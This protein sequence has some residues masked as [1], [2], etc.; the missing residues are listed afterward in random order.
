MAKYN[1]NFET[2][3][4]MKLSEIFG[5]N[6]MLISELNEKMKTFISENNLSDRPPK[7]P[8]QLFTSWFNKTD[9][10]DITESEYIEQIKTLGAKKIDTTR[11]CHKSSLN[12]IMTHWMRIFRLYYQVSIKNSLRLFGNLKISKLFFN[13]FFQF[14]QKTL[15][16][17]Q[18]FSYVFS[19]TLLL[20]ATKRRKYETKQKQNQRQKE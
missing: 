10:K 11:V 15:L 6:P 9:W 20:L 19:H 18:L 7:T 1:V 13:I 12:S 2:V 5:T 8:L 3:K 14:I 16:I 4:D 17:N